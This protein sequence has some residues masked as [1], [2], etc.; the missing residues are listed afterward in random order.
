MTLK[1]GIS[2]AVFPL[3]VSHV[4][5]TLLNSAVTR[6]IAYKIKVCLNNI[7]MCAYINTH[8]CMYIFMTNIFIYNINMHVN[9]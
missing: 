4:D 2:T 6:L 5:N 8:A 9:I 3:S 7:C 1:Y